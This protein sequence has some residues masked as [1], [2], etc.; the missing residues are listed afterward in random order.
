MI[1]SQIHKA[2]EV[3]KNG[4]IVVFPTD[5]AFGIGC[6]IDDEKT[7]ERLFK[8]RKRPKNMP[9]PVLVSSVEMAKLYL[10]SIP[11][12]VEEKLIKNFWPGALTIV[13]PC[14][15]EKVPGLVRGGGTTLGVRAPNNKKILGIIKKVGVPILGTSANFHGEKTPYRF[16]DLNPELVK[17]ADYVIPGE[18]YLKQLST[19]IDCSKKPWTILRLGSVDIKPELLL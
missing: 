14:K 5:T 3:L 7:I 2:V 18:T 1:S 15:V 8:I 9:T 13:L 6:R 16:E 11:K 12:D 19:V 4:G 10:K 17:L